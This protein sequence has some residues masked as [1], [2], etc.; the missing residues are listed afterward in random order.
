MKKILIVAGARPNFM[1]ISPILR[2]LKNHKQSFEYKLVHTGQH[3]DFEMSEIFF[4]ELEIPKPHYF[5]NVGSDTHAKQTANIMIKIE[6]V[7]NDYNPDFVVV[8]GDVNSTLAVSI[9]AKKMLFKV[10]HVESGLRSFDN[11]MPEEINRIITDRISDI[12]FVSEK[13]GIENLKREGIDDNKI[14]FVGNI[15]IDTLLYQLNKLNKNKNKENYGVITLHRPSNVDNKENLKK[16]I[17]ILNK[18]SEKIKLYFPIHPR[19]KKNMDKFKISISDNIILSQPLGYMD[20]LNLWSKSKFVITDSGGI[21]EE[22]TALKIPCFTLRESTERPIT[23]E[24]GSNTLI[25]NDYDLLIK[26][27]D[28][29]LNNKYKESDIPELWDG[30]TAKRIIEVLKNEN[31][32]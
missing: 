18:V 26:G 9:T 21:Q 19:T 3:Y 31:L 32:D 30:N 25:K 8:V 4:N 6:D 12:L 11:I 28:D 20:F 17:R 1:K 10:V 13:S 27:I 16:I 14:H 29:V 24:I 7:L 23:I 2:E 5:L 22:T 15:M